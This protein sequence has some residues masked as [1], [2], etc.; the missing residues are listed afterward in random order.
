MTKTETGTYC[1]GWSVT[2]LHVLGARHSEIPD[3]RGAQVYFQNW[4]GVL[5][6]CC[7]ESAVAYINRCTSGHSSPWHCTHVYGYSNW[8]V[9]I[10]RGALVGASMTPQDA[11]Q[12]HIPSFGLCVWR[13]INDPRWG[14][15]RS[16]SA[17]VL[18][19]CWKDCTPPRCVENTN[20]W[21]WQIIIR[22]EAGTGYLKESHK[23]KLPTFHAWLCRYCAL[24]ENSPMP[25]SLPVWIQW[26]KCKLKLDV[27]HLPKTNH[28]VEKE[29][30]FYELNQNAKD[31]ART[32]T[33]TT[34]VTCIMDLIPGLW[35]LIPRRGGGEEESER[36][37]SRRGRPTG[38]DSR[39]MDGS[40][41]TPFPER[42]FISEIRRP[43]KIFRRCNRGS[44]G[45]QSALT[46]DEEIVT[47]PIIIQQVRRS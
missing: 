28:Y 31:I 24:N 46:T 43:D 5:V 8:G 37:K 4:L 15:S 23:R 30:I 47:A 17:G 41:R 11:L 20:F 26:S 39:W 13:G 27:S 9:F 10:G 2:V 21:R 25:S 45:A 7:N 18:R 19:F 3:G 6:L 33:I 29:A 38:I 44:V 16:K 42:N 40:S 22:L 34:T 36:S 14:K 1:S 12:F 35:L 32:K